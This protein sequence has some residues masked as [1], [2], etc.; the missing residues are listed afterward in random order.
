MTL[1]ERSQVGFYSEKQLADSTITPVL[2]GASTSNIL[3]GDLE[4]VVICRWGVLPNFWTIKHHWGELQFT[5]WKK[6]FSKDS[7]KKEGEV[8][9][10]IWLR[11]WLWTIYASHCNRFA[12]KKV[13]IIARYV[14]LVLPKQRCW[15]PSLKLDFGLSITLHHFCDRTPMNVLDVRDLALEPALD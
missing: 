5:G 6:S 2:E 14:S 3:P 15:E 7:G 10:E 12:K 4:L 11:T 1:N 9:G 8:K 13:A